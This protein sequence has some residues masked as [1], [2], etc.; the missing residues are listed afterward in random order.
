VAVRRTRSTIRS[1]MGNFNKKRK[2]PDSN[3]I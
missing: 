3:G 2:P 1:R